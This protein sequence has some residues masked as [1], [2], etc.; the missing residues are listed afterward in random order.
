MKGRKFALAAALVGLILL[1]G[2]LLATWRQ[3]NLRPKR[4]FTGIPIA[5]LARSRIEP[6]IGLDA[7]FPTWAPLPEKGLVTGAETAAPRP[8]WGASAVA[9]VKI[10]EDVEPYMADYRQRLAAKG[11]RVRRLPTQPGLIVDRPQAQFQSDDR[12]GHVVYIT[13]RGDSAVRFVQ[14][15]YWSPPAPRLLP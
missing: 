2:L 13:F 9:M 14:L 6:S 10:D 1:A 4:T 15:T 5:D 11:F 12:D 3:A 8:P 7:P